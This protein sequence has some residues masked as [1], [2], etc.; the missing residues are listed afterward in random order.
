MAGSLSLDLPINQSRCSTCTQKSSCIASQMPILVLS[1]SLLYAHSLPNR[2][3]QISSTICWW[4][5]HCVWIWRQVN[6]GVRYAH[7][8]AAASL[9]RCSFWYYPSLSFL[10][11]L[12]QFLTDWVNSVA[13][14]ADCRFIVS[15]SKDKSIKVFDMDT[16]QQL[17]HFL[18]AHSGTISL[19]LSLLYVYSLPNRGNYFSGNTHGWQVHC[20]WILWQVDQGVRHAHKRTAASLFRRPFQY[21]LYLFG[22]QT[23]F[24]IEE[25][26]SVAISADGR[27][28]VSGSIDNSIKLFDMHTKRQLHHFSCAHSGIISLSLFCMQFNFLIDTITSVAISTDGRFIVSGSE[29][30]SIKVFDMHTKQQLHHF[31]DAHSSTIYIS[32]L[33]AY[34]LPNRCNHLN[35]NICW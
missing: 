7:K 24:P 31:S 19:S 16:K 34:S 12:T 30:N 35:G 1:I 22:I 20:I 17:Y 23:H 28:I 27:F 32:L 29:D 25:I 11:A 26:N 10:C 6:Q 14:S 18:D 9:L 15:G 4:Q 5:V 2:L 8:T 21:Y 13:I 33:Y 3:D